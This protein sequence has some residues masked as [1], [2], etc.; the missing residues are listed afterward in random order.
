MCLYKWWLRF[1][2]VNIFLFR[3]TFILLSLYWV[4]LSR[5]QC[6]IE[7]NIIWCLIVL[8]WCLV[9]NCLLHIRFVYTTRLEIITCRLL[10][11]V[12]VFNPALQ[13]FITC[14]TVDLLVWDINSV[15][16]WVKISHIIF[17]PEINLFWFHRY[18]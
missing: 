18:S 8:I 13:Q 9:S 15:S 5:N 11:I 17:S 16:W 1:R 2:L 10:R 4:W 6:R 12:L 7:I 14:L 3:N